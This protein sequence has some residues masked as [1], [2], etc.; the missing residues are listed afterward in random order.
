MKFYL[1]IDYGKRK[2]GLARA[3]EDSL[4]ALPW[5][6]IKTD[7][8]KELIIKHKDDILFVVLGHSLNLD[9]S[10]N[11]IQKEIEEFA[12]FLDGLKISYFYSDERFSTQA[13]L[14]MM[15]WLGVKEKS[16]RPK[17]AIKDDAAAAAQILQSYLD[18]VE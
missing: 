8:L 16:R 9:G 12:E 18:A 13:T 2:T 7:N 17:R 5:K 14:A 1:G 10:N 3:Y 15:K 11:K 4:I 6:I